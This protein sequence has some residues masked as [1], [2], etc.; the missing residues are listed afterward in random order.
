MYAQPQQQYPQPGFQYG[1]K[2]QQPNPSQFQQGF[3][4]PNVGGI[5]NQMQN[6]HLPQV[7][8]PSGILMI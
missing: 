7:C 8:W 2:Y 5:T 1:Q 6:M 3:Q 4:Q